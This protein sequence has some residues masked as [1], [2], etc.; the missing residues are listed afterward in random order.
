MPLVECL[1]PGVSM[2]GIYAQCALL[3]NGTYQVEAGVLIPTAALVEIC[4]GNEEHCGN[5]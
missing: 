2:I 5:Q 3:D 4:V 1:I